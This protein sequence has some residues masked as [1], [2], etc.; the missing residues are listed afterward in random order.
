MA[1]PLFP[2]YKS[3]HAFLSLLPFPH[4]NSEGPA[5][6]LHPMRSTIYSHIA[7]AEKLFFAVRHQWP[8]RTWGTSKECWQA[9][10]ERR[11]FWLYRHANHG[12]RQKYTRPAVIGRTCLPL[13]DHNGELFQTRDVSQARPLPMMR[14]ACSAT[15]REGFS[16]R[17][18]RFGRHGGEPPDGNVGP[19]L[20][21]LI[22]LGQD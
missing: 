17:I 2:H 19:V 12:F 9:N 16:Y 11:H 7:A 10:P 20:D 13:Q 4:Q 18:S 8:R 22:S 21:S 14:A 6:N 15:G 3:F 5:F 1:W